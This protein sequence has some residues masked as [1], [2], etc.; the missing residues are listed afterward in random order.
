MNRQ[1]TQPWKGSIRSFTLIELLVVIAIIA[2]LAAI[3]LPALNSARNRAHAVTCTNNLKQLSHGVLAYSDANNGWFGP[4][5]KNSGSGAIYP[6]IWVNALYVNHY[7]EA[8]NRDLTAHQ[9][10]STHDDDKV[11]SLLACPMAVYRDA[12]TTGWRIGSAAYASADYGFNYSLT[13]RGNN[14]H[15]MSTLK[16]PSRR[17]VLADANSWVIIQNSW[18]TVKDNMLQYRHSKNANIMAGDGSVQSI[19]QNNF[20]LSGTFR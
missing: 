12:L 9:E 20:D 16:D 6:Y 1:T 13:D 17:V 11:T 5:N 19:E 8:K 2:I 4:I 3:L 15:R 14:F 7:I 18:P 10:D